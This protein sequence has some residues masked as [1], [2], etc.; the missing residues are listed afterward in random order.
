MIQI[1]METSYWVILV[2]GGLW[3]LVIFY[4]LFIN[5]PCPYGK[6]KK[7]GRCVSVCAGGAECPAN[8]TCNVQNRQCEYACDR[9]CDPLKGETC[10]LNTRK[11][12]SICGYCTEGVCDYRQRRCVSKCNPECKSNQVCQ[13]KQCKDVC[14]TEPCPEGTFCNQISKKCE[15]PCGKTCPAG[16]KCSRY[17]YFCES[18]CGGACEADQYCDRV[19]KKCMQNCGPCVY[20][21]YRDKNEKCAFDECLLEFKRTGVPQMY[22]PVSQKCEEVTFER[23]RDTIREI[24]YKNC[25]EYTQKILDEYP[26]DPV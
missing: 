14:G 16:T 11:C 2:A 17:S 1:Y 6:I 7:D 3:V 13:N 20:G 21:G 4:Y 23:F 12:K 5:N 24:K 18:D 22:D 10:D 9:M 26:D 15:N 19:T 25:P 8:Y